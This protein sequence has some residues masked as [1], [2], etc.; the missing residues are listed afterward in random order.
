MGITLLSFPRKVYTKVPERRV[1]PLVE[2]REGRN[3]TVFVL[4][5]EPTLYP[6]QDT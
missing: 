6:L 3:N 1:R 4:V 5:T 2:L